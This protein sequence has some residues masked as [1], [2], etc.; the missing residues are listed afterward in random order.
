MKKL[1][2]FLITLVLLS[3][4][5]AQLY[6]NVI[7]DEKLA[8]LSKN[9]VDLSITSVWSAEFQSQGK[10]LTLSFLS[11]A[12]MF[13]GS[14]S[15]SWSG[16]WYYLNDGTNEYLADNS[17]VYVNCSVYA[18]DRGCG[19]DKILLD[20]NSHPEYQSV[21]FAYDGVIADMQVRDII[22]NS[23]ITSPFELDFNSTTG[24]IDNAYYYGEPMKLMKEAGYISYKGFNL[25]YEHATPSFNNGSVSTSTSS[26]NSNFSEGNSSLN[27]GNSS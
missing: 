16:N 13:H 24:K 2:I 18:P 15:T 19:I 3:V 23:S 10:N 6:N 21:N 20:F 22:Q 25:L 5:S 4:V 7:S 26:L 1:V 8:S 11:V 27:G 14:N 9:G 17:I 12:E